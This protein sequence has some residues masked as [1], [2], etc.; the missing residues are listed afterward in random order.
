MFDAEMHRLDRELTC[1]TDAG[2]RA[3]AEA[4]FNRALAISRRQ[5][6]KLWEL[7]AAL[8]LAHMWRHAGRAP[9]AHALASDTYR[10][11]AEGFETPDLT[12]ARTFLN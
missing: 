10:L 6:A 5:G 7:H 11:F 12:A 3:T 8:S 2:G 1:E 4:A 9:E